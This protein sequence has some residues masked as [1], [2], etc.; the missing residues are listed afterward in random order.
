M[1]KSAKNPKTSHSPGCTPK[2]RKLHLTI[3]I[4][5]ILVR[6]TSGKGVEKPLPREGSVLTVGRGG[7]AAQVESRPMLARVT[8]GHHV[9]YTERRYVH[10]IRTQ[11]R[12][13]PLPYP[14]CVQLSV[15]R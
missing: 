11:R 3:G 12:Q 1:S 9:P 5:R 2:L 4:R 8:C 15:G 13:P 14:L 6:N 7:A 10:L